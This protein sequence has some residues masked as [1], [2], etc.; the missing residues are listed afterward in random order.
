MFDSIYS[1]VYNK[2]LSRKIKTDRGIIMFKLTFYEDRCKGCKLCVAVCPK[3]IVYI[4]N[5]K[6]NKKGFHPAGCSDESICIGCAS[7][8]RICPDCVIKIEKK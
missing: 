4:N 1:K 5:E 3:K 6:I 7:C 2:Y 8:A